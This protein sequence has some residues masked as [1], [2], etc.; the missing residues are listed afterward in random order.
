[1]QIGFTAKDMLLP[2]YTHRLRLT[3]AHACTHLYPQSALTFPVYVCL[4]WQNG[5][6]T[7]WIALFN[8]PN[9]QSTFLNTNRTGSSSKCIRRLVEHFTEMP[10]PFVVLEA[11][12]E[13][14]HGHW[15][16]SGNSELTTNAMDLCCVQTALIRFYSLIRSTSTTEATRGEIK[17]QNKTKWH[18]N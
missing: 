16:A 2:F 18:M 9:V 6:Y 1:M 7:V 8:W 4:R 13:R 12:N 5:V 11:P 17:K 3:H 14:I 15:K 10:K